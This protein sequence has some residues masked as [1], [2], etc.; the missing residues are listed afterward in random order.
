MVSVAICTCN[1]AGLL[2]KS[3]QSV[4]PQLT[5]HSELLIVD[6]AS[7]DATPQLCARL[8]AENPR[9]RTFRA[10]KTLGGLNPGELIREGRR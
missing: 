9:I 2:E 6:N 8:S 4:L 7:T 10:G 5:P 1:R 3:V